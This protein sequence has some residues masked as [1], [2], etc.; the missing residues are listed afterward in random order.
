MVVGRPRHCPIIIGKTQAL[1]VVHGPPMLPVEA[2]A[3]P[4]TST[5]PA[6]QG[7]ST[8]GGWVL[9]R[10]VPNAK[11]HLVARIQTPSPSPHQHLSELP[12]PDRSHKSVLI[13]PD[14]TQW[15]SSHRTPSH[16]QNSSRCGCI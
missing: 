15:A 2:P 4:K 8:L 5:P 7:L 12:R 11:S 6:S 1:A 13:I 9:S 14:W 3:Q 10:S 16:C